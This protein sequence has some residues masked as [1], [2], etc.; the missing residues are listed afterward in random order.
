MF[1][2]LRIGSQANATGANVES[3]QCTF[4]AVTETKLLRCGVAVFSQQHLQA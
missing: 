1:K 4:I 2:L 3:I